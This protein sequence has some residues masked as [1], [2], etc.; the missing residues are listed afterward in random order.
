L[1]MLVAITP[2]ILLSYFPQISITSQTL[3][4]GSKFLFY[5]RTLLWYDLP[6]VVLGM[7][8]LRVLC[9]KTGKT[10]VII[11]LFGIVACLPFLVKGTAEPRYIFL[12][13]IP[14]IVS[15]SFFLDT[16]LTQRKLPAYLL[17]GLTILLSLIPVVRFKFLLYRKSTYLLAKDYLEKEIPQNKP[18]LVNRN[19]FYLLPSL[20]SQEPKE[21]FSDPYYQSLRSI[22]STMKK[23][24]I[25]KMKQV[26]FI[27]SLS[28]MRMLAKKANFTVETDKYDFVVFDYYTQGE[29][30]VLME[31]IRFN[32]KNY[33]LVKTFSPADSFIPLPSLLNIHNPYKHLFSVDRFGPYFEVYEKNENEEIKDSDKANARF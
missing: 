12:L 22:L 24:E 2:G 26:K 32:P 15:A 30:Q 11:W 27:H 1:G 31:E 21:L 23:G 10:G 25:E 14:F 6:V 9:L 13:F 8:G 29:K 3:T 16:L 19:N 28:N 18:L 17:I 4:L 33:E 7:V 20:E 5:V